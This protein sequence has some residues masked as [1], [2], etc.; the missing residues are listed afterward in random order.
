[1]ITK[2][3]YICGKEKKYLMQT[4]PAVIK[5]REMVERSIPRKIKTPADFTYLSGA[6]FERCGETISETTLKRIWGYIGGYEN[7]RYHTLSILAHFVGYKD[8]DNF[9]EDNVIDPNENSEEIMQRCIR[10]KNLSVGDKLYFS[11]DPD[12]ECLVEYKGNDTFKVLDSKNS[13]LNKNDTFS[14]DIFIENQL[15]YI[16]DLT[17]DNVTY[18]LFVAGKKGGLKTIEKTEKDKL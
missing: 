15:L 9:L 16:D 2:T 8:W 11:W 6:I 14:C 17:R 12:R 10:S 1:M 4:N 3:I 7:I 13:K 18:T 5:L